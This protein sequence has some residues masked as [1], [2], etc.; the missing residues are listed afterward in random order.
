VYAVLSQQIHYAA[1]ALLQWAKAK[2]EQYFCP[3]AGQF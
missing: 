2:A 1:A 3:G